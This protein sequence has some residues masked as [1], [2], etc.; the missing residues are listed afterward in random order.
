M[1]KTIINILFVITFLILYFLQLN[2]FS[3]FK[4][5][6]AMPNLFIILVFYIGLFAGRRMGITYGIVFGLLLDFLV[7]EKIGIT[8]IMLGICGI[9]GGIFDKNFSKDSRITIMIMIIGTTIIYE[10]GMYIL[11]YAILKSSVEILSFTK[12]L[13]AETVFNVILTIIFYPFMQKTGH[14]VENEYKSSTILTR[15]F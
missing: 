14:K 5:A 7:G 1:K 2:F 3:W 11:R 13:T 10:V 12:L 15:Y 9:I 8:A 6:G 4:I